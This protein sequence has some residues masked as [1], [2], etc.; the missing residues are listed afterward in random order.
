MRWLRS[1]RLHWQISAKVGRVPPTQA[2]V[3]H[4]WSRSCK[5]SPI[6]DM[7]L[8]PDSTNVWPGIGQIHQIWSISADVGSVSPKLRPASANFGRFRQLLV[9]IRPPLAEFVLGWLELCK[10]LAEICRCSRPERAG[11]PLT[12]TGFR[13]CALLARASMRQVSTGPCRQGV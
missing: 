1:C 13:T 7:R 3:D 9:R 5:S 11:A 2:R 4:V 10:I 6:S 8:S 12:R